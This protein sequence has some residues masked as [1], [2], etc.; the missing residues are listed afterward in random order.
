MTIFAS[1]PFFNYLALFSSLF[2]VANIQLA[3]ALLLFISTTLIFGLI[4]QELLALRWDFKACLSSTSA[5]CHH[6]FHYRTLRLLNTDQL[7]FK[8]AL[9]W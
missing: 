2:L 4:C 7:T 6:S 8:D 1:L 9:K 5:W 3:F